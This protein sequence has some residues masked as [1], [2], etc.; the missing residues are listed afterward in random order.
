MFMAIRKLYAML[1]QP[2]TGGLVQPGDFR[3]IYPDGKMTRWISYGDAANLQSIH[4][5][6]V[7]WRGD[8]E[9]GVPA[10]DREGQ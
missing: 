1:S 5:G 2:G 4:G 7:V 10:A 6:K 9:A 8:R 3:V